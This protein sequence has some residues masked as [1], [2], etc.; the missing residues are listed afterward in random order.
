MLTHVFIYLYFLLS[1]DAGYVMIDRSQTTCR[2]SGHLLITNFDDCGAAITTVA[3]NYPHITKTINHQLSSSMMPQGCNFY[4]DVDYAIF[5]GDVNTDP[6]TFLGLQ[7]CKTCDDVVDCF[8]FCEGTASVDSVGVCCLEPEKDC[9]GVCAG[10]HVIDDIG[11]CCLESER[12]C[13]GVCAGFY[14][15]DDIGGCC[16]ESEKDCNGVC[17][18]DCCEIS[19]KDCAGTCHGPKVVDSVGGC[20]LESEKDCL[21]VCAGFHVIDAIGGCCLESEKDCLGVCG[22]NAVVDCAGACNGPKVVDSV[23][24]CCLKSEQDCGGTC[25]GEEI[26]DSVGG[27]C[28]V[29]E[30]DCRGVCGNTILDCAGQCGGNDLDCPEVCDRQGGELDCSGTCNGTA[31]V[32]CL[33]TC[34]GQTECSKYIQIDR[35]QTTCCESGHEPITT[36]EDCR[37]A[38]NTI[39]YDFP[40][41]TDVLS[42]I[43]NYGLIPFGRPSGCNFLNLEY[44]TSLYND[45]RISSSRLAFETTYFNDIAWVEVDTWTGDSAYMYTGFQ[46]CLACNEDTGCSG[47]CNGT[48]V[49]ATA[50]DCH[51]VCGGSAVLDSGGVCCLESEKDCLGVCNGPSR[52]SG[53]CCVDSKRDCAGICHG[54]KVTDSGGGCC[55][56]SEKDCLGTCGGGATI[57]CADVCG[58]TATV[59][60]EGVCGGTG[61]EADCAGICGGSNVLTEDGSCVNYIKLDGTTSCLGAGYTSIMEEDECTKALDILS[62]Q[63][64]EAFSVSFDVVPVG[65]SHSLKNDGSMILNTK[66]TTTTAQMTTM[67]FEGFS[68]YPVC[69]VLACDTVTDCHGVCGG[70]AILDCEG[71]CDGTSGASDCA[72]GCGRHVLT[73]DGFCIDYIKLNGVQTCL[74]AGYKPVRFPSECGPASASLNLMFADY[75]S[76]SEPQVYYSVEWLP[77]GCN[78]KPNERLV[79]TKSVTNVT[80]RLGW[81]PICRVCGS[82]SVDCAGTPCGEAVLDTEGVCCT[83]SELN[84]FGKCDLIDTTPCH[85]IQDWTF[86]SGD[87]VVGEMQSCVDQGYA[88]VTDPYEC[89]AALEEIGLIS[90]ADAD[91]RRM[92]ERLGW[93]VHTGESIERI[94]TRRAPT[95]CMYSQVS[96]S[97]WEQPTENVPFIKINALD[98]VHPY[99]FDNFYRWRPVCK[100]CDGVVDCFGICNGAAVL[101]CQGVCNGNSVLD[102]GGDCCPGFERDCE[103]TCFGTN[104]VDN[105]GICC[106]ESDKDCLGVCGGSAEFD[107]SG[108][109]DG[110]HVLA[111]DGTC[112]YEIDGV[113][114]CPDTYIEIEGTKTCLEA[115]LT[116]ITDPSECHSALLVLSE[117]SDNVFYK[118]NLRVHDSRVTPYGCSWKF[119]TENLAYFNTNTGSTATSTFNEMA[120]QGT[121]LSDD[122]INN[123]RDEFSSSIGYSKISPCPTNMFWVKK[124]EK[125]SDYNICRGTPCVDSEAP[126]TTPCKFQTC[127]RPNSKPSYRLIARNTQSSIYGSAHTS[128]KVDGTWVT[129]PELAKNS[130]SLK[131]DGVWRRFENDQGYSASGDIAGWFFTGVVEEM[132]IEGRGNKDAR[133]ELSCTQPVP[134]RE[135]QYMQLD[136]F[137]TCFQAGF[138]PIMTEEECHHAIKSIRNIDFD[139]SD[140]ETDCHDTRTSE[141]FTN[142]PTGCSWYRDNKLRVFLN[143]TLNEIPRDLHSSGDLTQLRYAY[144]PICKLSSGNITKK[145]F[146]M[147]E[148]YGRER[149][150]INDIPCGVS[151][152]AE[153]CPTGS[154]YNNGKCSGT[155]VS[156]LPTVPQLETCTNCYG[157]TDT[158]EYIKLNGSKTCVDAGHLE[159]TEKEQCGEAH[160]RL[161]FRVKPVSSGESVSIPTEIGYTTD[162]IVEIHNDNMP[163]GCLHRYGDTRIV[164]NTHWGD[165]PPLD[166]TVTS[167]NGHY[168]VCKVCS[169]EADCLGH[170]GGSAVLDCLGTCNGD[171]SLDGRAA[172]CLDSQKDCVGTCG[173]P[174]TTGVGGVCCL[175]SEKDCFGFCGDNAATDSLGECCLKT[176]Q[177]CEGTCNGTKLVDTAGVCCLES[178]KDCAGR[179]NGYAQKDSNSACC[180]V[181]I[182]CAGTCNGTKSIGSHGVCCDESEKDCFGSCNG[183]AAIHNDGICCFESEIDC[184]GTC[185]GTKIEDNAGGCC[186]ENELDCSGKCRGQNIIGFRGACCLPS[187]MDCRGTCNGT[188]TSTSCLYAPLCL[189]TPCDFSATTLCPSFWQRYPETHHN[190]MFACQ[191]IVATAEPPP[192]WVYFHMSETSLAPQFMDNVFTFITPEQRVLDFHVS[193]SGMAALLSDPVMYKDYGEKLSFDLLECEGSCIDD[194][195]CGGDL[196]CHKRTNGENTPGCTGEIGANI[197]VCYKPTSI[198]THHSDTPTLLKMEDTVYPPSDS[199]WSLTVHDAGGDIFYNS[200]MNFE[201]L[202]PPGSFKVALTLPSVPYNISFR[203]S[204]NETI[205]TAIAACAPGS[206]EDSHLQCLAC[207]V[208]KQSSMAYEECVDVVEFCDQTQTVFLPT[209]EDTCLYEDMCVPAGANFTCVCFEGVSGPLCKYHE[210]CGKYE[211]FIGGLDDIYNASFCEPCPPYSLPN[212]DDNTLCVP[213]TPCDMNACLNGGTCTS[214]GMEDWLCECANGYTGRRCENGPG[215]PCPCLNGGMCVLGGCECGDGFMGDVCEY[216]T[217]CRVGQLFDG[218]GCLDTCVDE[219]S[220]LSFC[221]CNGEKCGGRCIDDVCYSRCETYQSNTNGACAWSGGLCDAPKYFYKDGTTQVCDEFIVEGCIS[222]NIYTTVHN[223][224][225][226]VDQ[227][228]EGFKRDSGGDCTPVCPVGEELVGT[229]CVTMQCGA[230]MYMENGVCW[231][232]TPCFPGNGSVAHNDTTDTVCVPCEDNQYT[233]VHNYTCLNYSVFETCS[234]YIL[235]DTTRGADHVCFDDAG[236][237][238]FNEYQHN[239]L[240][241]KCDGVIDNVDDILVCNETPLCT[242]PNEYI[243]YKLVTYKGYGNRTL[244]GRGIDCVARTQCD[245]ES[246]VLDDLTADTIC[247]NA[248]LP[249]C[250]LSAEDIRIGYANYKLLASRG[251]VTQFNAEVPLR[252]CPDGTIFNSHVGEELSQ[253]YIMSGNGSISSPG[254]YAFY[255]S[256]VN[257]VGN[258][259]RSAQR[260]ILADYC[261]FVTDDDDYEKTCVTTFEECDCGCLHGAC[262]DGVCN[263]HKAWGGDDCSTPYVCSDNCDHGTC[264]HDLSTCECEPGWEGDACDTSEDDCVGEICGNGNCVD[265][266]MSVICEC[267][268]GWYP[269]WRPDPLAQRCNEGGWDNTCKVDDTTSIPP[270]DHVAETIETLLQ[271]DFGR[272]FPIAYFDRT[273]YPGSCLDPSQMYYDEDGVFHICNCTSATGITWGGTYCDDEP[274]CERGSTLMYSPS[275]MDDLGVIN[276]EYPKSALFFEG[277]CELCPIG[278]Y[279]VDEPVES[280]TLLDT[281]CVACPGGKLTLVRGSIGESSCV[282]YACSGSHSNGLTHD[283]CDCHRGYETQGCVKCV[284]QAYIDD[285]M[286]CVGGDA[287]VLDSV[288]V[289]DD[290]INILTQQWK[291]SCTSP[292]C[293]ELSDG[294]YVPPV[295][296]ENRLSDCMCGSTYLHPV[297]DIGVEC[298]I[299]FSNKKVNAG[300]TWANL[301]GETATLISDGS[302]DVLQLNI[303]QGTCTSDLDCFG[304]LVCHH[305]VNGSQPNLGCGTPGFDYCYDVE[306]TGDRIMDSVSTSLH[307]TFDLLEAE[308]G[309]QSSSV[310]YNL[311]RTSAWNGTSAASLVERKIESLYTMLSRRHIGTHV[312]EITLNKDQREKSHICDI[313]QRTDECLKVDKSFEFKSKQYDSG[314]KWGSLDCDVQMD[315]DSLD[316]VVVGG[317]TLPGESIIV[318]VGSD[319]IKFMVLNISDDFERNVA[320]AVPVRPHTSVSQVMGNDIITWGDEKT[321]QTGARVT[322][323]GRIFVLS[324]VIESYRSPCLEG[325]SEYERCIVDVDGDTICKSPC[326]HGCSGNGVCTVTSNTTF[327]CD[328]SGFT[329]ELCEDDIDECVSNPCGVGTCENNH[330]GYTCTCPYG[331]QGVRE[332]VEIDPFTLGNIQQY[333]TREFSSG[334]FTI[335]SVE[336]GGFLSSG[337]LKLNGRQF[338][339]WTGWKN[340]PYVHDCMM[341]TK[342]NGECVCNARRVKAQFPVQYTV[343][344]PLTDI[345]YSA[346]GNATAMSGGKGIQETVFEICIPGDNPCPGG[347]CINSFDHIDDC[348]YNDN[349]LGVDFDYLCIHCAVDSDGKTWEGDMCDVEVSCAVSRPEMDSQTGYQFCSVETS[350]GCEIDSLAKKVYCKCIHGYT[351]KRCEVETNSCDGNNCDSTSCS[352]A[353][354]LDGYFDFKGSHGDIPSSFGYD[355]IEENIFEGPTYTSNVTWIDDVQT[356]YMC[357]C[358]NRRVSVDSHNKTFVLNTWQQDPCALIDHCAV[359]TPEFS[360]FSGHAACGKNAGSSGC[361]VDSNVPRCECKPGYTGT[362]CEKIGGACLN[363]ECAYGK[364]TEVVPDPEYISSHYNQSDHAVPDNFKLL[365]HRLREGPYYAATNPWDSGVQSYYVCDCSDSSLGVTTDTFL[366]GIGWNQDALCSTRASTVCT[367]ATV[368]LYPHG[369]GLVSSVNHPGSCGYG[370]KCTQDILGFTCECPQGYEIDDEGKCSPINP[371]DENPCL[372]SGVCNMT[373]QPKQDVSLPANAPSFVCSCTHG[374]SGGTCDACG[375]NYG[376]TITDEIAGLHVV[377]CMPCKA[378]THSVSNEWN[379]PC[380]ETPCS[381]EGWLEGST[382]KWET[383]LGCCPPHQGIRYMD[384]ENN[385]V[386]YNEEDTCVDGGT[387]T[388]CSPCHSGF[389]NDDVSVTC[390]PIDYCNLVNADGEHYVCS[391]GFGGSSCET[392]YTNGKPDN[393]KCVCAS[394][395]GVGE[396]EKVY[397]IWVTKKDRQRNLG[398]CEG[399]C[400]K[401]SDCEGELECY[402]RKK[403]E[404]VPGCTGKVDESSFGYCYAPEGTNKYNDQSPPGKSVYMCDSNRL[405]TENCPPGRYGD[406]CL[407]IDNCKYYENINGL[408]P[409]VNGKCVDDGGGTQ[410]FTCVCDDGFIGDDCSLNDMCNSVDCGHGYCHEINDASGHVYVCECQAGWEGDACGV[411]IDDCQF[412]ECQHGWCVDLGE[413]VAACVCKPGWY[414]DTCADSINTC[415]EIECQ[416]VCEAGICKCSGGMV[417]IN[418]ETNWDDCLSDPCVYG[419]CLD[420]LNDYHCSCERGF[421]GTNCDQCAPGYGYDRFKCEQCETG[422]W[423]NQITFDEPCVALSCPVGQEISHNSEWSVFGA[424]C[425]DC[426]DGMESPNGEGVCSDINEC[427][428]DNP[429]SN[430]AVC[431]NMNPRVSLGKYKCFCSAGY[432]G[433]HCDININE[434]ALNPCVGGAECVDLVNDYRCLCDTGYSG[435]RCESFVN[436]CA[437]TG[438]IRVD[439]SWVDDEYVFDGEIFMSR[440]SLFLRQG[441]TY[442]FVQQSTDNRIGFAKSDWSVNIQS[443]RHSPSDIEEYNDGV[444]LS[445]FS[446]K[447]TSS[448]SID[449]DTLSSFYLINRG[450][451]GKSI[452]VTTGTYPCMNGGTCEA[453]PGTFSCTCA[454]GYYGGKCE[455]KI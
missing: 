287:V 113:R 420:M 385:W 187:E 410:T 122:A 185:S 277:T 441:F 250:I 128:I 33:G 442:V 455:F 114:H 436:M 163:G 290:E 127:D 130:L 237:N 70:N 295:C 280:V 35:A 307:R 136:G 162:N 160:K 178:E 266:H 110:L 284:N 298:G 205:G 347:P 425:I 6:K 47:V 17:G 398:L 424:T 421:S 431:L 10:F 150:E 313:V 201:I 350:S 146:A 331:Y 349:T 449:T 437:Q 56:E 16:L 253:T 5:N 182:D 332:C 247:T 36:P 429:C 108:V 200:W 336:I 32:D 66:D 397:D 224:D 311:F 447:V 333:R 393:Y 7:M 402:R 240:C 367:G 42:S 27:C 76:V 245:G 267:F 387:Q 177:D 75:N 316:T 448:I 225:L 379:E 322:Y 282:E 376:Y 103:G 195:D 120:W 415:D 242:D 228:G 254:T 434:C 275:L 95:G 405:L 155:S 20:C 125:T 147:W 80:D 342:T 151:C 202:L 346:L 199:M 96:V 184:S 302:D 193:E 278:S 222:E 192:G 174:K 452:K 82:E 43:H 28:L 46:M 270:L 252:Y 194:S 183:Y 2:D 58:G 138:E 204:T 318:C 239:T 208:G 233:S 91:D 259:C 394:P 453:A 241:T 412:L 344:G 304:N 203:L 1:V 24:S 330:G 325:C 323:G 89:I 364:C 144:M 384:Y 143:P 173:G 190:S 220:E 256:K 210:I 238:R 357:G 142:F 400:Y 31:V 67:S 44:L 369:E 77:T 370:G 81:H 414:G 274:Q 218:V 438:Q 255:M 390:S 329:G 73:E 226:C 141:D 234:G 25:N 101:D 49:C 373:I 334:D 389:D 383:P 165:L 262:V 291:T 296:D 368:S 83:E 299:H 416:G 107:C 23:G 86:E 3:P 338:S 134:E 337:A 244:G 352:A 395:W 285:N 206:Y 248:S 126:L 115:G 68:Y 169:V 11:G 52:S 348:I 164:L 98:T 223:E 118:G 230:D 289:S 380:V 159:I 268:L 265:S 235:Q 440:G 258:I 41:I 15:I 362:L 328:C 21:S 227:C 430:G 102:N 133:W 14:V 78:H 281:Q 65:C 276:G 104:T 356:Y 189:N 153:M 188:E 100:L 315:T 214:T 154:V 310:F 4:S 166:N 175:E 345:D 121:F 19:E 139:C 232:Y 360:G 407:D 132:Y 156:P 260:E 439:V 443:T 413:G 303:C 116:P 124:F 55:L 341:G 358:D 243:K 249:T 119:S 306:R 161:R 378:G 176:E 191:R 382:C 432:E 215:A 71:V 74:E 409:C 54:G 179:C 269:S 109:C 406:T 236:C 272:Q 50:S 12:D 339:L 57:D 301:T 293:D 53:G 297:L 137:S 84:C 374:F 209:Y 72:G 26:V 371:C 168:P 29:T 446:G 404:A 172:C 170:C 359:K 9:L 319:K 246:V 63:K 375:V 167:Y 37:A 392:V 90:R 123:C 361:V 94:S 279:Y 418:C 377:E 391:A 211:K 335:D 300:S 273:C 351:G 411:K 372:N 321:Y 428:R 8:G 207:P 106:S 363:H 426:I 40:H 34:N 197:D 408:S 131:V 288:R 61:G 22:G 366:A 198:L 97:R 305:V 48:V 92:Y 99:Y 399:Y 320:V 87:L 62:L 401:D 451:P 117:E 327:E 180:T 271:T 148:G 181:S 79:F 112:C 219:Y 69:R 343:S 88:S 317:L 340:G 450:V 105:G 423:N 60:C 454:D 417:G 292:P 312:S 45:G 64:N 386:L 283:G 381:D 419:E 324:G 39:R 157:G 196:L 158:D 135:V 326:D 216:T 251:V 308:T 38:I 59:D 30:I 229:L 261:E 186:F 433:E 422:K 263:C 444:T 294:V 353:I 365:D 13:L 286:V 111:S 309:F 171:A 51:G 213:R 388:A 396:L 221:I 231:L 354:V 257:I 355:L 152:S 18:G 217:S 93:S 435:K 129:D 145:T 314:R 140:S 264:Q 427:M 149:F 403:S 445:S 212:A 85:S